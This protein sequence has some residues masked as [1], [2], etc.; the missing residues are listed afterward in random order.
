MIKSK[1]MLLLIISGVSWFQLLNFDPAWGQSKSQV[2]SSDTMDFEIL[3]DFSGK[4]AQ[5]HNEL[6]RAI[7]R[8]A[9]DACN[10]YGWVIPLTQLTLHTAKE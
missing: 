8:I 6:D 9:V 10:K 3:A 7:Q 1:L 4:V 2:S 5:Y